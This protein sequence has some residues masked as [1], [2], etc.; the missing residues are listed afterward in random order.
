[1]EFMTAFVRARLLNLLA[2][3]L[4]TML[5]LIGCGSGD[6]RVAESDAFATVIPVTE[7]PSATTG[8]DNPTPETTVAAATP[9]PTV[10]PTPEVTRAPSPSA[11]PTPPTPAP[12]HIQTTI[13]TPMPTSTP[14][15]MA[16]PYP[17]VP[18]I[19]DASNRGWPRE[20]E[21][22]EG[23]VALEAPP[24]RI[25][26]YS[27]GHDEL[28]LSLVAPDRIAAVGKFT[29]NDGYS[30]VV[31]WV[32]DIAVYEK[33]AENVLA[34]EPDLF[35]ASKFTKADIVELIKE[36]GVPV[37]R[38]SLENSSEGNIPNILLLGYL[39]GVEERALELAGDIEERLAAVT[40][41]VPPPGDASRAEVIA[42][43]RY[44]ETIYVPG[45][46]TTEGGIIEAAGGNNVAAREGL[47]G[48]QKVSIESVAAMNPEVI[49]ITQT[50]ESGGEAL[51]NDLLQHPALGEVLAI[52]NNR[53]YV[54]GSKTFTTLSHW[55]LRGIE[56]TATLL[57][58]EQ[59]AGV[60]FTDFQPYGGE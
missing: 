2:V 15:P 37:V 30:N 14:T 23:I 24:Q 18:G 49:L 48:I 16:V 55:N 7:N 59:F 33:G 11:T 12:T 10:A 39:L 45:G 54:V 26:T 36:A 57:Y 42:I 8:T 32:A 40:E 53:I 38:P 60:T 20:V 52:V 19:V 9:Q 1:M 56:E 28:V 34:Q 50:G 3:I 22:V 31:D 13:A 46:G 51:R 27:L 6:G 47:E 4:A 29:T 44:S 41:R 43:T 21:T 25:L 58:P 5:V 17:N 35:I